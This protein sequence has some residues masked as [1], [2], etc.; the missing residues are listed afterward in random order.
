MGGV[1][2]PENLNFLKT[3][4]ENDL[5]ETITSLNHREIHVVRVR[6]EK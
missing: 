6:E 4:F 2:P 1:N 3:L 5:K